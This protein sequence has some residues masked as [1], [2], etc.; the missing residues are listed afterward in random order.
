MPTFTAL[1]QIHTFTHV[2]KMKFTLTSGI[3]RGI[4]FGL[5]LV[6][7]GH[8]VQRRSLP[9]DYSLGSLYWRI[10][11]HPAV[12]VENE[13]GP[14]YLRRA[15]GSSAPLIKETDNFKASDASAS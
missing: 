13:N 8:M 4:V 5:R 10:W 3:A 15:A 9:S 11:R 6:S 2:A 14:A 12:I 1:S 7:S